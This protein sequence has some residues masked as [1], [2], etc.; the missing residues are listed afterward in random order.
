MFEIATGDIDAAGFAQVMTAC[1]LD[2]IAIL[3]LH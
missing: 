2:F 1:Q 3:S